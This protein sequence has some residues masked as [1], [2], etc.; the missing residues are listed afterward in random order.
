[1]QKP[2]PQWVQ[3]LLRFQ[4]EA[5]SPSV[6]YVARGRRRSELPLRIALALGNS[7]VM[8]YA[9]SGAWRSAA[10]PQRQRLE[11]VTL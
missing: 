6:S 2:R 8:S 4:A 9:N 11:M 10:L 1:M 3:L 5:G 7:R